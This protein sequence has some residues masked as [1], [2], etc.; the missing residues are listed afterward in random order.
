MG[1]RPWEFG[2]LTP[3]EFERMVRGYGEATYRQDYRMA[4]LVAAIYNLGRDPN[5]RRHPFSP[6]DFLARPGAARQRK[7]QTPEEM[8]AVVTSLHNAFGGG[9]S[10]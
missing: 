7:A 9:R 6:D 3:L 5:K 1:L 10:R 4:V 2:R 8:L